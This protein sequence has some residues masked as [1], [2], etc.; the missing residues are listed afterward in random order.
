MFGDIDF[1]TASTANA[2]VGAASRRPPTPKELGLD[3][4]NS[5]NSMG[6]SPA[7]KAAAF[8]RFGTRDASSPAAVVACGSPWPV[9]ILRH[10]DSRPDAGRYAE[11]ISVAIPNDPGMLAVLVRDVGG[12]VDASVNANAAKK[13]RSAMRKWRAFYRLLNTSEVRDCLDAHSGA[14]PN[15]ARRERFLQA[16]FFWWAFRSMIP[17]NRAHLTA[18]PA[19]M[20]R[21][22]LS[23]NGTSRSPMRRSMQL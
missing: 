5:G 10:S 20:A 12:V 11:S 8:P 21:N 9:P 1:H 2:A 4:A 23:R 13:D 18:K 15:G 3:A 19:S 22:V 6:D 17:R 16:A 14:D 7:S